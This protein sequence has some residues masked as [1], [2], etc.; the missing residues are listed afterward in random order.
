[1]ENRLLACNND[2]PPQ[3][4]FGK[5]LFHT[6]DDRCTLM[7]CCWWGGLYLGA[8][9]LT[10]PMFILYHL[11]KKCHLIGHPIYALVWVSVWQL[12]QVFAIF[13]EGHTPKG[14]LTDRGWGGL[15]SHLWFNLMSLNH[16]SCLSVSSLSTS[17]WNSSTNEITEFLS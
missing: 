7:Q 2:K 6:L 3:A 15:E 12:F 1:M 13:Q 5:S 10:P 14:S 8:A 4:I 16:T 9:S 11:S 17:A